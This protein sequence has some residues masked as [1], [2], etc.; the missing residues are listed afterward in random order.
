MNAV[1]DARVCINFCHDLYADIEVWAG[2]VT[3]SLCQLR[4]EVLNG[5]Y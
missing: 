3:V 1:K 2:E 5:E 4:G